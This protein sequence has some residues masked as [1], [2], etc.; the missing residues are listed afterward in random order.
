MSAVNRKPVNT[1][2]PATLRSTLAKYTS[3]AYRRAKKLFLLLETL[4]TKLSIENNNF[5]QRL[6]MNIQNCMWT[7]HQLDTGF[8]HTKSSLFWVHHSR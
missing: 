7:P 6:A 3:S 1:I 2:S 8:K 5:V 4:Q